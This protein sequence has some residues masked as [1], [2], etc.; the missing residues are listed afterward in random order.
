MSFGSTWPREQSPAS[1]DFRWLLDAR[2]WFLQACSRVAD[3]DA[4]AAFLFEVP[5]ERDD[6]RAVAAVKARPAVLIERDPWVWLSRSIKA[7]VRE[8]MEDDSGA[9]RPRRRNRKARTRQ[10]REAK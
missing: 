8:A 1:R 10:K 6:R 4:A 9:P 2:S 5:G 7:L 3:E